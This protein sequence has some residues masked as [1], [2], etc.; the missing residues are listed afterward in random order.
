MNKGNIRKAAALLSLLLGLT[1]SQAQQVLYGVKTSDGFLQRKHTYVRHTFQ[2]IVSCD[3]GLTHG[4]RYGFGP[5]SAWKV[6]KRPQTPVAARARTP[7]WCG[8]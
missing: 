6:M 1:S 5:P 2:Y 4:W 3:H 7:R 8:R